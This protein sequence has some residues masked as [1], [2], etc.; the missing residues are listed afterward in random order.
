MPYL[1][2]RNPNM[3]VWVAHVTMNFSQTYLFQT[4]CWRTKC[5]VL[6]ENKSWPDG[7]MSHSEILLL[8]HNIFVWIQGIYN[9]NFMTFLVCGAFCTRKHG[10]QTT[11]SFCTYTTIV[12]FQ[13]NIQ[14]WRPCVI[15]GGLSWMRVKKVTNFAT[16][17]Y[18]KKV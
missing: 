9:C 10:P 8:L 17:F 3:V 4:L 18:F 5:L 14:I 16:F 6:F 12:T 13:N 1:N 15:G 2:R 7:L 11:S